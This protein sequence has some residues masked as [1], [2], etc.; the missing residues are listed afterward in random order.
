MRERRKIERAN[1]FWIPTSYV[2]QGHDAQTNLPVKV[3]SV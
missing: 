1:V 2:W 3:I